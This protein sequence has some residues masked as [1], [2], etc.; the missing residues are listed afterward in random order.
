MT[1]GSEISC[2]SSFLM[3]L[4]VIIRGSYRSRVFEKHQLS[5]S[6]RESEKKAPS[7]GSPYVLIAWTLS[8]RT[9]AKMHVGHLRHVCSCSLRAAC[10]VRA[11]LE[12]KSHQSGLGLSNETVLLQRRSTDTDDEQPSVSLPHLVSHV[13]KYGGFPLTMG[14]FS[15]RPLWW[16]YIHES[17]PRG[18]G[19]PAPERRPSLA[20]SHPPEIGDKKSSL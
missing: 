3:W 1:S 17:Q 2:L 13:R 6:S 7:V 18:G 12:T 15:T 19:V 14:I 16:N 5:L 8:T 11:I 20:C 9:D 10:Q 4:H